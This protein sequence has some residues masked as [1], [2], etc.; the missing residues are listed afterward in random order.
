VVV[1]VVGEDVSAGLGRD[2][3][4]GVSLLALWIVVVVTGSKAA[5][6]LGGEEGGRVSALV[7]KVGVSGVRKGDSGKVGGRGGMGG[8]I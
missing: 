3:A 6:V 5:V 7:L 8:R 4:F 1:R 2:E